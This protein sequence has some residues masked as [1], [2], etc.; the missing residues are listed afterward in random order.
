M[1]PGDE[2]PAPAPLSTAPG[3]LSTARWGLNPHCLPG[4]LPRCGFCAEKIAEVLAAQAQLQKAS[5]LPPKA[6]I[7]DW[8]HRR[9]AD[10]N[11]DGL[12]SRRN[13]DVG[14]FPRCTSMW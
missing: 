6:D 2:A 4:C 12:K 5:D 7:N 8:P 10:G 3:G 13:R 9:L 1:I 14:W 11:Y